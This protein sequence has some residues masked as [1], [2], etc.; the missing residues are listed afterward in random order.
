MSLFLKGHQGRMERFSALAQP[1]YK[2]LQLQVK[3]PEQKWLSFTIS[4]ERVRS[5][6]GIKTPLLSYSQI[7]SFT[8]NQFHPATSAPHAGSHQ[9]HQCQLPEKSQGINIR[10]PLLTQNHSRWF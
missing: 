9:C 7:S 1:G 3:I 8:V 6:K 2:P 5:D 4:L 10:H